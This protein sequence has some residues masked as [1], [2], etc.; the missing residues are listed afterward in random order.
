MSTFLVIETFLRVCERVLK[1]HITIDFL[2]FQVINHLNAILS[3]QDLDSFFINEFVSVIVLN[4]LLV[5][6][7]KCL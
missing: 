3:I 2:T 1:S 7:F 5:D 6:R 4:A